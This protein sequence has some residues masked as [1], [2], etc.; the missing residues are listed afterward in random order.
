MSI[1]AVVLAAAVAG[2]GYNRPVAYDSFTFHRHLYHMVMVNLDC[3]ACSLE[4][5]YSPH[6]T[7][8]HS[9]VGQAQPIAAITG[10]F[11]QPGSSRCVADVVV[12]GNLVSSGNRGTAVAV[13]YYGNVTIFDEPFNRK[14][15]WSAYKFGLRGLVRVVDG[16]KVAPNPRAQRFRDKHIWGRASRT[17]LGLTKSGKLVLFGTRDQV[18][19]TEFGQAMKEH[20]VRNGVSLDG[21]SSTCFYYK[22]SFLIPPARKLCNMV[23][24]TEKGQFAE[25]R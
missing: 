11:F 15:D 19:L 25:V 4:T 8:A 13:D 20:G 1:T 21:G 18:S 14:V 2:G 10:T 24:V 5:V 7:S 12:D 23:V 22:G 17:G 6:L 16:G 9:L 3:G